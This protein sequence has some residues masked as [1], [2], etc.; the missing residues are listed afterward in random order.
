MPSSQAL[1]VTEPMGYF[2]FVLH[3]HLPYVVGHGRWP[4]GMDWLNEAAAETYIPLLNVLYALVDEGISPGVTMGLTP[5][6][7]EQLRDGTFITEFQEYLAM[8]MEAAVSDERHF[9]KIGDAPML[10]QASI[11]RDTYQGLLRDFTERYGLDIVGAFSAL[12]EAG[13]I[14]IITSGATH[15][16]LPL[17]SQDCSIQAQVRQGIRSHERHFGRPPRGMWLPECA[18]RPGYPWKPPIAGFS[19]E[20]YPRKGV[21]EFLSENEIDYFIIDSHMLKGGRAIGVYISRFEA[22]KQL[23]GQYEKSY[24]PLP[25]DVTKTPYEPFLVSSSLKS[26]R[27][28]AVFTRDP[29]TSI[30][31]WSGDAG[32]PGDGSYLDFHKKR[33]PGGLRYWKVTSPKTDMADKEVYDYGAVE[34]RLKENAFHFVGLVKGILSKHRSETGSPGILTAPFDAELLGH[35]WF[36]GPRWLYYVLKWLAADPEL[37][38][39]TCGKY[40][41]RR[42]TETVISIPEGSWGEGGFHWIWLN[43]R[44]EWSWR[45]IY[46]AEERM[47][48]LAGDYA[49]RTEDSYLQRVLKQAARELLLLQSSDWQF[50]ISTWSAKDYAELRLALHAGD[51]NR[52]AAMAESFGRGKGLSEGDEA[53]LEACEARDKLFPD[54]DPQWWARLDYPTGEE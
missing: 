38:L 13:H 29:E 14:E 44:T 12:Q 39:T 36:E 25:E 1:N 54:I 4:H 46:A 15:G 27:P 35:W 11:W 17:L 26:Q 40:L 42:P 30:Q 31:V 19:D 49:D 16:Y 51:F 7:C 6:L 47:M 2:T 20:P 28:V 18:Y 3:A 43:E 34:A 10:R 9:A 37:E 33:F 50:L 52:L 21:E 32:Y 23:W 45:H 41:E 5:V 22:L 53:F 24:Q 48:K 8:K